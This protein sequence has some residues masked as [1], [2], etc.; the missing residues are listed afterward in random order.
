MEIKDILQLISSIMNFLKWDDTIHIFALKFY[1]KYNVY[2][3]ILLASE[4]TY[5]KIDLYAQMHPE[6]LYDP[7]GQNTIVE[8][9]HSYEGIDVFVTE[10]YS[11]DCCIDYDLT[12]GNITLV[13]DEA[14]DFSGEP[15]PEIEETKKIYQFKKSA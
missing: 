4:A 9:S 2:P 5:K 12:E 10:N 7:D 15:I 3:N 1:Q 8:S 14:P 13:F 6:R 11:L